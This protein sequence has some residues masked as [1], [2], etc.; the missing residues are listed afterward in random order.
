MRTVVAAIIACTFTSVGGVV[1]G[2]YVERQGSLT[3]QASVQRA[4]SQMATGRGI[5]T[6][7]A[8]RQPDQQTWLVIT[9]YDGPDPRHDSATIVSPDRQH[10]ICIDY[11]K[12][13][14]MPQERVCRSTAD[15][16]AFLTGR[17]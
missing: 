4:Q 11:P 17:K 12:F 16:A 13:D 15:V 3:D 10:D 2:A 7:F 1:I 8:W 6:Y 14:D 5:S 9:T